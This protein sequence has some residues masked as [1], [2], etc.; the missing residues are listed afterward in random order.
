MF[1]FPCCV[2]SS[3]SLHFILFICVC[4]NTCVCA[5]IPRPSPLFNSETYVTADDLVEQVEAPLKA[6]VSSKHHPVLFRPRTTTTTPSAFYAGLVFV[7]RY[8]LSTPI[9]RRTIV[10]PSHVHAFTL[11]QPPLPP[12]PLSFF[13][14]LL[15]LEHVLRI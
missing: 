14:V 9:Y 2:C 12:P 15:F 7:C 4:I 6:V 5:I 10:L 8:A 11:T 1:V 3:P 13:G